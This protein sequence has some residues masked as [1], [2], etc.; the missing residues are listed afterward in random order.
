MTSPQAVRA[1]LVEAAGRGAPRGLRRS[2][3]RCSWLPSAQTSHRSHSK[4]APHSG[5]HGAWNAEGLLTPVSGWGSPL[6]HGDQSSHKYHRTGG[7]SSW[8]VSPGHHYKC[9]HRKSGRWSKE[10]QE[11]T[12]LREFKRT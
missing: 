5:C 8:I 9:Q 6:C 4:A 3:R 10:I 12:V 7:A 11:V 1:M 2:R